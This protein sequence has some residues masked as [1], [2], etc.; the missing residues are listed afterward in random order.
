MEVTDNKMSQQP[1]AAVSKT[2][3]ASDRQ[4]QGDGYLSVLQVSGD[5]VVFLPRVSFTQLGVVC[6]FP[7]E[8]AIIPG[9]K[10][11]RHEPLCCESTQ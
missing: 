2:K 4:H 5:Q 3:A 10:I 9:S 6:E 11:L 8:L 1:P 7:L